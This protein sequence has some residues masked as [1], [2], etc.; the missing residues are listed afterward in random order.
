LSPKTLKDDVGEVFA[1][2]AS[3]T[4][5]VDLRAKPLDTV[6]HIDTVT[7]VT[8]CAILVNTQLI[9]SIECQK[10]RKLVLFMYCELMC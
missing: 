4:F 2:P 3:R 9:L 8:S 10:Y 6:R 1:A 7:P 5:K